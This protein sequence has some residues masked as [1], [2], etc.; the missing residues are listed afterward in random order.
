MQQDINSIPTRRF[1]RTDI[2]IPVLS[3]GS[4]RFQ[5]SWQ[6]LEPFDI[7]GLSQ[8]QLENILSISK[9]PHMSEEMIYKIKKTFINIPDRLIKPYEW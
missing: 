2:D 9:K 4:M 5:E 7:K 1:G 3:L 6:D 8:K